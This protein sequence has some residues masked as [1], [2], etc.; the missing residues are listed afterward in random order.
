MQLNM[1]LI[2]L[3]ITAAFAAFQDYGR[4]FPGKRH[5]R[6]ATACGEPTLVGRYGVA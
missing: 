5:T 3:D 6:H 2:I 1:G 4:G